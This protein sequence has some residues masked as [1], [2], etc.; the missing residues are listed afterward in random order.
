[1]SELT[2]ITINAFLSF[3]LKYEDFLCNLKDFSSHL[4]NIPNSSVLSLVNEYICRYKERSLRTIFHDNFDENWSILFV[5][6]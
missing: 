4:P 6:S 3:V 1:M 2:E 5:D